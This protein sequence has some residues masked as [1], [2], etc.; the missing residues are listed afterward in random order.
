MNRETKLRAWDDET[1]EMIYDLW[2]IDLNDGYVY[3]YDGKDEVQRCKIEGLMQDTGLKDKNGKEIY[4]SDL[5]NVEFN[6]GS[7]YEDPLEVYF[8]KGAFMVG[9]GYLHDVKSIEVIGNSFENP[10]L[11]NK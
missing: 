9:M 10:N 7:K 11:L 5:V 1:K 6:D 8:E 4:G 2:R 3:Y